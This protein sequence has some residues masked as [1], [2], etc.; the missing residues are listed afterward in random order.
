MKK[1]DWVKIKDQKSRFINLIGNI[2]A[3]SGD[4]CEIDIPGYDF[5]MVINPRPIIANAN[6]VIVNKLTMDEI[7][8]HNRGV[9]ETN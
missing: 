4:Y 7:R 6:L 9:H 3:V 2:T 8:K 1:Y 5:Q